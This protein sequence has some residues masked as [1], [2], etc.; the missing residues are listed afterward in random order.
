MARSFA[1]AGSDRRAPR[2][3]RV[4]VITYDF[5]PCRTSA[6]YRMTG[7][8]KY[9]VDHGWEPTVLTIEVTCGDQEPKL[10]E[11]L[12]PEVHI[13]RTPYF[14]IDGWERTVLSGFREVGALRPVAAGEAPESR[15]ADSLLRR[16]AALF[17]STFYFPDN[18][19]GW[20]PTALRRALELHF[21]KRF[22]A[23]FTTSPPRAASVVGLLL[24]KLTGLPWICE[25]MDPWYPHERPVRRRAE[26]WLH[27]RM[28]RNA[29]KVVV[30]VPGHEQELHRNH[31]V[32]LEKISVIRNGYFE[33][34][35][36]HLDDAPA[37]ALPDGYFHL[38]HFGTIY[39]TNAGQFFPALEELVCEQPELKQRLRIH[40]TGYPH[41]RTALRAFTEGAL[42][43]ITTFHG[44]LPDR[45]TVLRMMRSSDCLLLFWGRPDFSRLAVA[46]KTY[47][48][49]R[50]G[51]PILAVTHPGGVAQLVEEGRAGWVVPP[52]DPQAIKRTLREVLSRPLRN[53]A[54]PRPA[55]PEFVAQFRWD[56]H[57]ARL[58]RALDEVVR[59]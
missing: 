45:E 49:L 33:E 56:C 34:D 8:T 44:F 3:R 27:A 2:R 22:D 30:M 17:R 23:V 9:L 46:G 18:T 4:L 57:A 55:R 42:R 39:E 31:G 12:P 1:Q 14:A 48:Y 25:L 40:L 36:R 51:R 54:P 20:I 52:D 10:L 21:K 13:E 38:S 11:K 59:P 19:A 53:G 16:A 35:Y 58:A 24:K 29:D 15:A 32:P 28:M 6:V 5:P 26:F 41:D 50:V 43:E 7:L 37:D 47:E